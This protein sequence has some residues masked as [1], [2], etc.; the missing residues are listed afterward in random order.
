MH[1]SSFEDRL[2]FFHPGPGPFLGILGIGGDELSLFVGLKG[3]G[4]VEVEA[5]IDESLGQLDG[6]RGPLSQ[7]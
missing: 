1:L 5:L 6:H 3:G 2:S 7:A 4:Q